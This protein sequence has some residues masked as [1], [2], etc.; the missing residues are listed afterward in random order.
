[1][2]MSPGSASLA[3]ISRVARLGNWAREAW[4]PSRT[5]GDSSI[6]GIG[7]I[8]ERARRGE[9]LSLEQHRNA[10][11][12]QEIS[13]HRAKPSRARQRVAALAGAGIGDLVVVL[14]K[15][16][17]GFRREIQCRRAARFL[18]PLVVLPLIEKTVFRGG[19]ELA[20]GDRGNPNS[21]PRDVRSAPPWR[22]DESRHSI[23]RR[24]R[25]RPARPGAPVSPAA[26]RSRRRRTYAGRGR[27]ANPPNNCRENMIFRSIEN[28]L[29]RV[30]PQPVEMVLVDPIARVGDE[31]FAHSVR[32]GARRN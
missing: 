28:G 26:A 3:C 30:E 17:K 13:S 22:Y 7:K 19:D 14:Q 20:A 23:T 31:E 29:S 4:R 15:D 2:S 21:R 1:M 24:A 18:L 27:L 32:N 5:P 25:I 9:F 16:Y 6:L 10:R 11:H 8:K 12:Q